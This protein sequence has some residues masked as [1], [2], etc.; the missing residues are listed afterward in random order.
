MLP[1]EALNHQTP[2]AV[3]RRVRSGLSESS[4]YGLICEVYRGKKARRTG[5]PFIQ[6]I[7]EGVW[8]LR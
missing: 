7:D 6:H 3:R 8:W 4:A 1:F 5:V 2:E